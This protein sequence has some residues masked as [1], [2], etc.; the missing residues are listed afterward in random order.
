MHGRLPWD[1]IVE[2][3]EKSIFSKCDLCG[4]DPQCVKDCPTDALTFIV[5]GR[6]RQRRPHRLAVPAHHGVFPEMMEQLR[7]TEFDERFFE[8]RR[9]YGSGVF[10][11]GVPL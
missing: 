4:G 6:S 8:L 7:A 2:N 9:V 1:M 3:K 5:H 10:A 11:A